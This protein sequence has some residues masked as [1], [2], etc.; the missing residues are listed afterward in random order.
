METKKIK[1]PVCGNEEFVLIDPPYEM[2]MDTYILEHTEYYACSECGLIYRFA[3]GIVDRMKNDKFLKTEDGQ[4]WL[5]LKQESERLADQIANLEVR[6][7]SLNEELE[8]E[9]RSIK[10]DKELKKEFKEAKE[11]NMFLNQKLGEIMIEMSKLK[12]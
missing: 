4:K 2:G 1:C 10:R 6:L 11:E 9:N 12:K 5:K 8:D 3:K 7:V